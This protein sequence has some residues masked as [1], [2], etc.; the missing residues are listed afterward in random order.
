MNSWKQFSKS[1]E[2]DDTFA[3]KKAISLK[4]ITAFK[5][6]IMTEIKDK[7]SSTL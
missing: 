4:L 3:S 5:D 6:N 2:T 1:C 7:V